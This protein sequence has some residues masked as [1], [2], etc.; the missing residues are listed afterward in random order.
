MSHQQEQEGSLPRIIRQKAGENWIANGV[1]E[2]QQ[3]LSPGTLWGEKNPFFSLRNSWSDFLLFADRIIQECLALSLL[4][5]C[6][7]HNSCQCC[8]FSAWLLLFLLHNAPMQGIALNCFH[9]L[10]TL[11]T[12]LSKISHIT[13]FTLTSSF[14]RLFLIRHPK[15]FQQRIRPLRGLPNSWVHSFEHSLPPNITVSPV[16]C[17]SSSICKGN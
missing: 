7:A 8:C 11:L 1:A 2:L 5:F 12:S 10:E 3:S 15:L 14:F 16:T 9:L 13:Q 6:V 17:M 4:L